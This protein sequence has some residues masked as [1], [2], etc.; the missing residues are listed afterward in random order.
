MQIQTKSAGGYNIKASQNI[1]F[2]NNNT[3]GRERRCKWYF[4]LTGQVRTTTSQ[5]LSGNEIPFV[6]AGFETVVLNESNYLDSPRRMICSRVNENSKLNT[7]SGNKSMNLR[8]F[9]NATN[10]RE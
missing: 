10:S 2:E 6:D 1:P 5:S 8:L 7:I 9:L 4:S 3:N